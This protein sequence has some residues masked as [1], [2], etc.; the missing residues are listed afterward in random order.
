MHHSLNSCFQLKRCKSY[1]NSPQKSGLRPPLSRPLHTWSDVSH[2]NAETLLNQGWSGESWCLVGSKCDLHQYVLFDVAVDNFAWLKRREQ[3]WS[4]AE[5][6]G[7]IQPPG[8]KHWFSLLSSLLKIYE[9]KIEVGFK[10]VVLVMN[11]NV[12][13]SVCGERRYIYHLPGVIDN[14]CGCVA[15]PEC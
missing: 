1:Q 8:W 15:L 9:L 4:W 6:G 3:I 11:L 10:H 12:C 14:S 13:C 5:L 2:L 7:G